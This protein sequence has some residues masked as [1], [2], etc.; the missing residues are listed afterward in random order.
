MEVTSEMKY[1]EN[2][3]QT[4]RKKGFIHIVFNNKKGKFIKERDSI[5][6]NRVYELYTAG[7]IQTDD[8]KFTAGLIFMHS[9]IDGHGKFAYDVFSDLEKNGTTTGA[10]R[11]GENWKNLVV[12]QGRYK[13]ENG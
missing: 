5:R 9:P 1:I 8:D 7:Q 6:A 13:P 2:T 10:R 3:D 12:K 11:N 4:D